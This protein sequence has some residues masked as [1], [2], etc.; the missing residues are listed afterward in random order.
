MPELRKDPVLGRW[1]IIAK[2]RRKRPTDFLVEKSQVL[3]G[4]CPLCPGNEDFTPP[5]V[6]AYRGGCQ[7]RSNQS[8]WQVR[9]VPNKYPALIIEGELGKA[10]E[11]LYDRMN[12][13]GAHEVIIESPGHN[14][15]L[16]NQPVEHIALVLRVYRDR[17]L[18]LQKDSR[19]R[20]VMIFKNYGK[21]AGASLEHSHSQL[22]ALPVLPRMITNELDGG[23]S[24]FRY[25]DRCLFC[26]IIRQEIEQDVR[27]VCQ[28]ESF[29]TISPFAPRTP[30]EMWVL[31]KRHTSGYCHEDDTEL[32]KLARILSE[33]LRRLDGCISNVPYNF[34]L[35]TQPLRSGE[36]EHFHWHF[37]IVPKLT[38]I[39]G[40]EWGS[41][42][43]INPMPPEEA[44]QYLR[45]SLDS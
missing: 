35:H 13:I 28:N 39:A 14:D 22:I 15:Q 30:F 10:A 37:E 3:G 7:S 8:D 9:V 4:F 41:G 23:K 11:G 19:F 26:D 25:K 2:E 45:E 16:W 27:V 24:Y 44:T 5:E 1:I 43:Y 21:A 12:G 31:P 20:Y 6:L 33:S 34:V 40:F 38:S 29:I 36:L 42:F 18:D 17:L 32:L